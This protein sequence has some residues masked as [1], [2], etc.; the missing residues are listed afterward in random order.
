MSRTLC[1]T[2]ECDTSDEMTA[3]LRD[4]PTVLAACTVLALVCGC[5]LLPY[6]TRYAYDLQDLSQ[7][8]HGPSRAHWLG[9]DQ[10]GRDVATRLAYGGRISFLISG[11][12]V[13]V[14]TVTGVT[15][16]T[17]AGFY[18]GRLDAAL[19]RVTDIFLAF[20]DLL[21]LI[22]ITGLLG[23]SILNIIIA[24][25]V[26]GWAGMARQVRA[27][28][29]TLREQEF[30]T[31]ARALG[32]PQRR[33]M[34]RHV[35]TNIMTVA[36]VRASLDIG[37]VILAEA[38][39]SFLGIGVQPPMPSW[40]VMIAES[41]PYLRTYSY[42]TVV[43]SLV[44]CAAILSLTFVGE[45]VAQMLDPRWRTVVL[46]SGRGRR[47]PPTPRASPRS[48]TAASGCGS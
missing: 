7:L 25:S 32:A 41:L 10:F 29:L 24:L 27:E 21:F 5:V 48:T 14:H 42:L 16:G 30:V 35:L 47:R 8:F 1:W 4:R 9:T 19:M 2:R 22:L 39:L 20:P 18:G 17:V 31:A 46:A 23:S 3:L 45:G 33:I 36:L 12:A 37:P 34:V 44:L 11:T 43:P 38:T 26:V 28:A 13:V 15:A 40:G 6:A